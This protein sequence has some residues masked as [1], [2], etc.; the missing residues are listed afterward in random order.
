MTNKSNIIEN[1]AWL[2]TR[3]LPDKKCELLEGDVIRFGRIPFKITKLRL[4]M[5][6]ED[7]EEEGPGEIMRPAAASPSKPKDK[8]ANE[9]QPLAVEN[10][11]E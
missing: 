2:I 6:V 1:Y 9:D 7:D 4:D 11:E 5:T 3:F 10:K 8:E